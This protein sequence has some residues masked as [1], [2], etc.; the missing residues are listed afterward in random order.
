MRARP[1]KGKELIDTS[2]LPIEAKRLLKK[3]GKL[4]EKH[5][6]VINPNKIVIRVYQKYYHPKFGYLYELLNKQV[7]E[8]IKNAREN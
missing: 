6:L 1:S 3:K 2:T 5:K 4:I 8:V 7:K